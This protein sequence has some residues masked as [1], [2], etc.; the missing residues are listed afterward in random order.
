MQWIN[1]KRSYGWLSIALHWAAALIIVAMFVTGFRAD[2]AGD[3][4]DRE[5]R[6][7]LMGWHISIGASFALVL[8]AR[9]ISSYAQPRPTPPEQAPALKFLSSA[10]HQL[11]LLAV[12]I[13][14]I[15]GPLA[16]WSGGRAINVFDL[17][18]IPS[19][20]AT[21]NDGVHEFAELMHAIGRWTLLGLIALHILGALKHVFMDE[22]G[23]FRMI[24]PKRS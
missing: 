19:P 11:L 7:M 1:D 17:F 21:A 2:M 8:L 12:L 10:T 9:V 24:A 23:E 3:A 6:G 5:A 4:G 22:N 16:I 14:I 18:S 13:Q 15:S 20:F